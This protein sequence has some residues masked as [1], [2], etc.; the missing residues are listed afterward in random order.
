MKTATALRGTPPKSAKNRGAS[1]GALAL[2]RFKHESQP[3]RLGFTIISPDLRLHSLR[4]QAF[5]AH[6]ALAG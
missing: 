4:L 6:A 2:K 5:A 1:A 3:F